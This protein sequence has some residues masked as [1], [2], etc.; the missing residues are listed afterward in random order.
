[1]LRRACTDDGTAR[2]ERIEG[3]MFVAIPLLL[4][5][6]AIYNV[7]EFVT[8][9]TAAGELWTKMLFSLQMMSGAS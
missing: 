1:M 9:G 5:P 8:P 7:V 2:R 4:L 6:F 3:Q